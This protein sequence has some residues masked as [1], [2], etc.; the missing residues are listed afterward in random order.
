V[1][2]KEVI[3]PR[4]RRERKKKKK[5]EQ[6]HHDIG[7]IEFVKRTHNKLHHDTYNNPHI[8]LKARGKKILV[9]FN[10]LGA[11]SYW[12]WQR[13]GAA[14]LSAKKCSCLRAPVRMFDYLYGVPKSGCGVYSAWPVP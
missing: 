4:I 14:N 3:I 11:S 1:G 7:Q 9:S 6:N 10:G 2:L 8:H 13:S 12:A 5:K